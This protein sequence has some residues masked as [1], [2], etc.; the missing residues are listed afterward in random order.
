MSLGLPRPDVN[1]NTKIEKTNIHIK[2]RFAGPDHVFLCDNGNL[3]YRGE[4]Q[5]GYKRIQTAERMNGM[6]EQTNTIP[7]RDTI[8]EMI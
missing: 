6:M 5:R 1:T 2:E 4:A 7:E 8:T 3:F